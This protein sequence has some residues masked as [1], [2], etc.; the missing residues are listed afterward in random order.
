MP[1]TTAVTNA[2]TSAPGV[3]V[4]VTGAAGYIASHVVQQLLESGYLLSGQWE[5]AVISTTITISA[6]VTVALSR[7][8]L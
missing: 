6:A 2:N 5:L 1:T 8:S 3:V 4:C 7:S